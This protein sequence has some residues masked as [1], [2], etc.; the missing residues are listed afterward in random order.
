MQSGKEPQKA[1]TDEKAYRGLQI[2][3]SLCK[4]LIVIIIKQIQTWYELQLLDQQQGFRIGRGTTDGIYIVKR[5][6]QVTDQMKPSVY[7][8]LFI[9][10]TAAFDHGKRCL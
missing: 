6:H 2:G 1:V 7:N 10:L 3:S 8:T 5:I 9:D 4:L